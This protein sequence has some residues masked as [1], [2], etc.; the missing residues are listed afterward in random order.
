MIVINTKEEIETLKTEF[1]SLRN[2]DNNFKRQYKK[3]EF[4]AWLK[5]HDFFLN[6]VLK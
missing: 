3:N 4:K 5:D 1:E 2:D 6:E